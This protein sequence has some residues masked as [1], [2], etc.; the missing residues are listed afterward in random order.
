MPGGA[1]LSRTGHARVP[2]VR[3]RAFRRIT[4]GDREYNPVT[5]APG[6]AVSAIFISHS[7]RDDEA[8]RAIR[9]RL[10]EVL[11]DEPYRYQVLLDEQAIRAGNPWEPKLHRWLAECDGAVLILT[12]QA[13]A[14]EWVKKEA[15]ILLW[16]QS[17]GSRIVVIPLL[18]GVTEAEA[19]TAFPAAGIFRLQYLEIPD[20]G[21]AGPV[22]TEIA[23]EFRRA[24]DSQDQLGS[25]AGQLHAEVSALGGY[26]QSRLAAAL[27]ALEHPW[28]DTPDGGHLIVHALLHTEDMYEVQTAVQP[29]VRK[30]R[31][32]PS[33]VDLVSPIAIPEAAAAGIL[34]TCGRAPGDRVLVLTCTD[35]RTAIRYIHRASCVSEF[36]RVLP[37]PGLTAE[38]SADQVFGDIIAGIAAVFD[39]TRAR[40]DPDARQ[41]FVA[42]ALSAEDRRGRIVQLL[43]SKASPDHDGLP[44][45]VLSEL[46]GR[47]RRELPLLVILVLAW[48]PTRAEPALGIPGAYVIAP[49]VD[50]EWH[51]ELQNSYLAQLKTAAGS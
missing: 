35:P 9:E 42:R 39:P 4:N 34:A 17:L 16:R 43:P 21:L 1:A 10:S 23:E 20:G 36:Y 5:K 8:A 30:F 11:A 32:P 13:L 25:W 14:S 48:P 22:I 6:G 27:Q 33:F 46:V 28:S 3:R 15:A 51:E 49:A 37:P 40:T 26:D 24:V 31:D 7:S 50:D 44:L 2:W 38:K 47:L 12:P 19:E 41:A 18:I 29:V 45:K